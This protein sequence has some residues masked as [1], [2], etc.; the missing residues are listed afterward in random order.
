MQAA[1]GVE[2][3]LKEVGTDPNALVKLNHPE[4]FKAYDG[5]L[6]TLESQ[7]LRMGGKVDKQ[8]AAYRLDLISRAR[9]MAAQAR[10]MGVTG[11]IPVEQLTARL[12]EATPEDPLV[13]QT[14]KAI[15]SNP[16]NKQ[17]LQELGAK[18]PDRKQGII[19]GI[20]ELWGG[21][22]G[23]Q[24]MLALGG[25]A[26]G[27]IGL[28]S[29][30]TGGGIG[31][32]LMGAGGLVGALLSMGGGSFTQAFSQL[33]GLFTG[34]RET[35]QL[36]APGGTIPQLPVAGEPGAVRSGAPAAAGSPTQTAV[37]TRAGAPLVSG[38][39]G[40]PTPSAMP[41]TPQ[42]YKAKVNQALA[43]GNTDRAIMYTTAMFRNTPG[44]VENYKKL[45]NA[46]SGWGAG[47]GTIASH[48]NGA[49]TEQEA[50]MLID[51]WPAIK[52]QMGGV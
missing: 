36:T 35:P 2:G 44:G 34:Q 18:F 23:T 9:S 4:A 42:E 25:T 14:W 13:Q 52:T 41:S 24:K 3:F 16:E 37:S 47:A 45:D 19:G 50:Q 30:F 28:I 39:P 26:L 5:Q 32:A 29:A 43:S 11:A 8:T 51:N 31:S 6:K 46:I 22:N 48:S 12:N 27:V 38:Q 20:Q 40:A 1:A 17:L 49:L 21:M 10:A 33:K 7:V 15:G